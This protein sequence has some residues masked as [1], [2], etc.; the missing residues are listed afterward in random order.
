MAVSY[1]LDVQMGHPAVVKVLQCFH[2]VS[3]VEGHLFFHQLVMIHKVV[4]EP[5]II[6]PESREEEAKELCL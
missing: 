1:Y 3:D 5:A 4:Q 6:H 2:D